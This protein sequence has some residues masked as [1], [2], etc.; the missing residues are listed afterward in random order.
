VNLPAPLH[1]RGL[2]LAFLAVCAILMWWD[3]SARIAASRANADIAGLV[4][5]ASAENSRAAAG[6]AANIGASLSFLH[7]MPAE[8]AGENAV[9][10]VLS[11][12]AAPGGA[13]QLTLAE[14][15]LQWERRADLAAVDR[16]LK[17]IG[18]ALNIDLIWVMNG[19][20]DC[21]AASNAGEADS[22][23]GTNFADREYFAAAKADKRGRQFAVG[24]QTNIPGLFFSAPVTAGDAILGAVAVKMDLPH[25]RGWIDGVDALVSDE[26]GVVIMA[27]DPRREMTTLDGAL[28]PSLDAE[29]LSARYKRSRFAPLA[30]SPPDAHGLVTIGNDRLPLLLSRKSAPVDGLS[31]QVLRPV[32]ELATTLRAAQSFRWS[33][34]AVGYASM[35]LLAGAWHYFRRTRADLHQLQN[36]TET[37]A[38]LSQALMAEKE[39]A[40]AATIAKSDFLATMSHEIRTPM[41]GVMGTVELL[42]DTELTPAQRELVR[43]AQSSAEFLLIIINDILDYSKL[44]A[45]R[46]ELE[47]K[48]LSPSQVI[49]GV[50][51][52]LSRQATAKDLALVSSVPPDLPGWVLGDPTRLRQVL[53]N[54]CGNAIKFTERGEV[55]LAVTHRCLADG[56]MELRFAISDTG[57]GISDAA[58]AKLFTR[59]TQA[60]SSTT[61]KFGGSGLG[62]A[63]SRQLVE[64]MGGTIGVDSK[65]GTG[66][67]FWFTIRCQASEAPSEAEICGQ[68]QPEARRTRSLR[69]LVAEDNATNQMLAKAMLAK[70][71]HTVDIVADGRAAVAAVQSRVYDLVLMDVQMPEMDGPTATRIIRGLAGPVATIPIIAL[72]ANAMVGDRESYVAAG[73]SDYLSKPLTLRALKAALA[74]FADAGGVAAA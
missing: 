39:C 50:T 44:E 54:L 57:I 5:D 66:S 28:A 35:L 36:K 74:R 56:A 25:L 45:G 6:V 19:S 34:L 59:F 11:S 33:L 23:V 62:L 46:V 9:R 31:V 41:N 63:I 58:R 10:S 72:T 7:G 61:R 49:D 60:D 68:D 20:G 15:K 18:Q 47:S 32:R 1:W 64:L 43:T 16:R 22:L 37:L 55:R 70:L 27:S 65:E 69:V 73:M 40:Q 3:V 13:S 67:T 4:S 26:N 53:V 21:I 14:R 8:V 38:Q 42:L 51:S 30:I 17:E 48:R 52:L 12:V 29:Y 2:G 71:G 24:R